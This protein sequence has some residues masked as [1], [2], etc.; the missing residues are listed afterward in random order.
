MAFKTLK[1][2]NLPTRQIFKIKIDISPSTLEKVA[3][4]NSGYF[5]CKNW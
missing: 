5:W 1:I 3:N 2:A 4:G